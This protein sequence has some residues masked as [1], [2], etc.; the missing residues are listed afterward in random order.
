MSNQPAWQES[1]TQDAPIPLPE[2]P[3]SWSRRGKEAKPAGSALPP[4]GLHDLIQSGA[5]SRWAYRLTNSVVLALLIVGST[6]AYI[7]FAAWWY[8]HHQRPQG[9]NTG[10]SVAV[11]EARP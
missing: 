9:G 7:A 1:D 2:L 10:A 3:L 6:F 5:R 4:R 11:R 8:G